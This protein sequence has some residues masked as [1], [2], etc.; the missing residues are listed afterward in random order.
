MASSTQTLLSVLAAIEA[1][2]KKR[3]KRPAGSQTLETGFANGAPSS[4][5][6]G[7][8]SV[9][10]KTSKQSH[11][12]N[13]PL[14]ILGNLAGDIKDTALGMPGGIVQTIEHPID[15]AEAVGKDYKRRYGPLFGYLNGGG[16]IGKFAGE[17]ADHPLAPLLDAASVAT[18]GGGLAAKVGQSGMVGRAVEGAHVAEAAKG[19]AQLT[20]KTAPLRKQVSIVKTRAAKT[21][22]DRD[23]AEA[24]VNDLKAPIES[25]AS[26]AKALTK[27]EKALEDHHAHIEK[28]HAQIHGHETAHALASHQLTGTTRFLEKLR[29]S[30]APRNI[31]IGGSKHGLKE[32]SVAQSGNPVKRLRQNLGLAAQES[33]LLPDRTPLVGLQQRAKKAANLEHQSE[34]A[35]VRTAQRDMVAAVNHMEKVAGKNQTLHNH[36]A[37]ATQAIIDGV[38]PKDYART[39]KDTRADPN[40]IQSTIAKGGTQDEHHAFTQEIIKPHM[41]AQTTELYRGVKQAFQQEALKAGR[42]IDSIHTQ[43]KFDQKLID[44]PEVQA[45]VRVQ[46]AHE[47]AAESAMQQLVRSGKLTKDEASKQAVLHLNISRAIRGKAEWTPEQA[48]AHFEK[49][50]LPAPAYNPDTLTIG[51]AGKRGALKESQGILYSRGTRS[52]SPRNIIARHE[53]ASKITDLRHAHLMM[54]SVATKVKEGQPLPKDHVW[55]SDTLQPTVADKL[56]THAAQFADGVPMKDDYYHLLESER[57]PMSGLAISKSMQHDIVGG[58]KAMSEG[59]SQALTKAMTAWKYA[60]LATRPGFLVTNV[61][62]NSFM[63][64]LKSSWNF[65]AMTRTRAALASGVFKEH[66]FS[67]GTTFGSSE[68][69]MRGKG[70]I[71]KSLSKAANALYTATGWHEHQMRQ[72]LMYDTARRL[73]QVKAEMRRLK[74]GKYDPSANSGK[75]LF[76]AAYSAAV[77]KNPAIR[78]LVT[79]NMDDALGNYRYYT[80]QEKMLKNLSPFYSWERHSVRNMIRMYEDNPATMAIL[81]EIGMQGDKRFKRDFGN[82]MPAFVRSYIEDQY[83][84]TVAEHLGMGSEVNMYDFNSV[85]PYTTALTVGELMGGGKSARDSALAMLGPAVTGPLEEITGKNTLTGAPAVKTHSSNP[86]LSIAERVAKETPPFTIG[87]LLTTDKGSKKKLLPENKAQTAYRTMGLYFK[88]LDKQRASDM[89]TTAKAPKDKYGHVIKKKKQVFKPYPNAS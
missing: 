20:K 15:T 88:N 6:H 53:M 14:S 41:A 30:T 22:V 23:M 12:S 49:A 70:A 71:T 8:P 55:V 77:A 87:E 85:N 18:L 5:S 29:K 26:S 65:P 76:H 28:L 60:T 31:K 37:A 79:R 44:S 45:I 13:N 10:P 63:T 43:V 80:A 62:S 47:V 73:P 72:L 58:R 84:K 81:S 86:F 78:G 1:E 9:Q 52:M 17:I 67:E 33:R 40:E 16:D 34:M 89:N 3:Y 64:V 39:V 36:M 82:N 42:H 25:R 54:L 35:R 21:V 66:H 46:K 56:K 57:R 11:H 75:T 24:R 48:A 32:I 38:A 4:Y 74:G 2:Q 51:D 59:R 19:V 50:G 7:N 27:H 83:I 61:L 68:A 69:A